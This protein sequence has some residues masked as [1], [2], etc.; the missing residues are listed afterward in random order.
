MAERTKKAGKP[1][2]HNSGGVL[3][4]LNCLIWLLV[5]SEISRANIQISQLS[6]YLKTDGVETPE[7]P[8]TFNM[9]R[10]VEDSPK[11]IPI[12]PT[13]PAPEALMMCP[14]EQELFFSAILLVET[15][16]HPD[17]DNAIGAAGELG[18]Y[19]ITEPYWRDAV[20]HRP[21]LVANGETYQNVRDRG[22]AKQIVM[23]YIDRY[24]P[25]NHDIEAWARLHN[26]GPKW[27]TKMHLTD[28]YWGKVFEHVDNWQRDYWDDSEA[29]VR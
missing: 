18:A 12:L 19:Q 14:S 28:E 16:G 7:K 4:L 27:R 17:P 11:P 3:A 5:W 10:T 26:S 2:S 25:D 23:S 9:T 15:G 1:H 29:R 20:E 22:Y 24:E 21:E 6:A 8:V 13:P